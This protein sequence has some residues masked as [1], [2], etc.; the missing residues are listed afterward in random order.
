[1][2][3]FLDVSPRSSQYESKPSV[4]IEMQTS[5]H[6]QSFLSIAAVTSC[7]VSFMM[8]TLRVCTV[9]QRGIGSQE[10]PFRTIQLV[11]G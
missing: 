8:C 3:I 2:N 6:V 4:Q 10:E 5:Q 11:S 9:A 7:L 1:M